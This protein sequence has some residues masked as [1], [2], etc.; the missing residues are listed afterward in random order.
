MALAVSLRDAVALAGRFPLLAG[1]TLD[2]GEGE[3]VHISGPNGAGKSS[4]LRLCCGSAGAQTRGLRS[5]S[6]TIWRWTGARSGCS[7]VTSAMRR[8]S[9]RS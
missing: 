6:A 9:T 3:I 5:C 2:V 7:W 4:L 8:S 1:V